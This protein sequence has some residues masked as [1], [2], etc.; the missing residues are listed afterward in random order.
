MTDNS[1]ISI[2]VKGASAGV[3]VA[4]VTYAAT[5]HLASAAATSTGFTMDMLG[6][7]AGL[8][9]KFLLGDA[10][11]LAVRIV[12]KGAAKTSEA[13]I[14]HTGTLAAAAT[15]AV[16]GATTALTITLG[17]RIVEYSIEY[18]GK[19]S[20]DIAK[21]FSEAYLM[22]K[23]GHTDFVET[24]NIQELID[25][26]WIIIDNEHVEKAFTCENL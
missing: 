9:T 10:A 15:A 1:W 2:T 20:Q 25:N 3:V 17:T 6:E 4:A 18:G 23:A 14:K 12:T 24:G 8:G 11:G 5:A 21:R 19:I 26:E 7:A 16:A 13:S 22:Y